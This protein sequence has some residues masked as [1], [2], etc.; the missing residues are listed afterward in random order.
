MVLA[1]WPDTRYP[2]PSPTGAQT[3]QEPFSF[4]KN[5]V[6]GS[7]PGR[8]IRAC[9]VSWVTLMSEDVIGASGQVIPQRGIHAHRRPSLAG[10]AGNSRTRPAPNSPTSSRSSWPASNERR[11]GDGHRGNPRRLERPPLHIRRPAGRP[12]RS[13]GELA[14]DSPGHRSGCAPGYGTRPLKQGTPGPAPRA[15]KNPARSPGRRPRLPHGRHPRAGV[16]G[17]W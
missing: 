11:R 16:R 7:C 8:E 10:R 15:V 5:S 4:R 14:T 6:E 2:G 3:V 17:S 13:P 12:G 1:L 9:A